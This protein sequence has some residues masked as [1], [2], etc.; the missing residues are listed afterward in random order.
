MK[1]C[2]FAG[3]ALN[4]QPTQSSFSIRT[5]SLC[6]LANAG[7]SIDGSVTTCAGAR[8]RDGRHVVRVCVASGEG[9]GEGWAEGWGETHVE[10]RGIIT[11]V[12]P[13]RFAR[14]PAT[15]CVRR[16]CPLVLEPAWALGGGG[17]SLARPATSHCEAAA[18]LQQRPEREIVIPSAWLL[19]IVGKT[20][21][22]CL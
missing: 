20:E 12:G 11:G 8:A 5:V 14:A 2:G 19:K 4:S 16:S 21:S 18:W 1:K 22:L 17:C 7:S 9:W 3:T 15:G 10:P 6:C 13:A